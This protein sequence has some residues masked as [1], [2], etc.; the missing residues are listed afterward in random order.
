[1]PA[2][3]DAQDDLRDELLATEAERRS[4]LTGMADAPI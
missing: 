3:T 4:V 1:M 2:R